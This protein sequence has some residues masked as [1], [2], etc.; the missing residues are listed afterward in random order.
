MIRKTKFLD[1][2]MCWRT[3]T[4]IYMGHYNKHIKLIEGTFVFVFLNN[5]IF[6][7]YP[8]TFYPLHFVEADLKN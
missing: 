1:D 8:F 2:W 5:N 6:S 7:I 3:G 4:F